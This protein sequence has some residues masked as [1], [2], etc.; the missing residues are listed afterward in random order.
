ML[1]HMNNSNIFINILFY[2]SSFLFFLLELFI[3]GLVFTSSFILPPS[4]S[5]LPSFFLFLPLLLSFI[6]VISSILPLSFLGLQKNFWDH[7]CCGPLY[8][9]ALFVGSHPEYRSRLV[10]LE[11][12]RE[13][14][15]KMTGRSHIQAVNDCS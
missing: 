15:T 2:Q 12:Q 9:P 1:L 13:D 6:L 8:F 10:Q 11:Q 7:W 3:L 14:V 5:L 4:F